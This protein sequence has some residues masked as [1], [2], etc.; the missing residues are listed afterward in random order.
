MNKL[1]ITLALLPI[2]ASCGEVARP[3]PP[4]PPNERVYNIYEEQ[5]IDDTTCVVAFY[6]GYKEASIS[7]DCNWIEP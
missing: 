3:N 1:I 4:L 2:M 5:L 6:D 7:I